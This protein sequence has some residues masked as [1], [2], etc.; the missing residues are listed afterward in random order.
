[1][2]LSST[3]IK[4]FVEQHKDIYPYNDVP[5]TR[6]GHHPKWLFAMSRNKEGQVW[7]QLGYYV[8]R[9]SCLNHENIQNLIIDGDGIPLPA[10][11][12]EVVDSLGTWGV[13]K[14]ICWPH[15]SLMVIHEHLKE[16]NM[17]GGVVPKKMRLSHDCILQGIQ[18]RLRWN[19]VKAV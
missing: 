10:D 6:Q 5:K 8:I 12:A 4:T 18:R 2:K 14:H 19:L 3:A 7:R 16:D 15:K 9:A 1:M 17:H 11:F 13:T